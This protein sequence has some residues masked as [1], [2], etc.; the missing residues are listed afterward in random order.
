MAILWGVIYS[1]SVNVILEYV[2]LLRRIGSQ[3]FAQSPA[4]PGYVALLLA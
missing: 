2:D 3:V 4:F 1:Q